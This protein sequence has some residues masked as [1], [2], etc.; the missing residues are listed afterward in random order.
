VDRI[1]VSEYGGND[2]IQAFDGSGR[3]L[4]AFGRMG[5][6]S[7]PD[8]VEFNRPQS[9]EID[10]SSGELVVTDACNNRVGR[11]T[12]DGKLIA[13]MGGWPGG[14][15]GQFRYPYGLCLLGD[16]TALVSEFVN[17]RVQRIDLKTGKGLAAYGRGG[18][19]PGELATP[20]AVTVLDGRAYVLDSGHD[21]ILAFPAPRKRAG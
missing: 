1:Y 2:R 12:L 9:I 3:F 17:D 16:G 11:F 15:L 6:A 21:R 7:G 18:T 4:F 19:G 8:P 5:S 13:W 20:W 14:E 10:L